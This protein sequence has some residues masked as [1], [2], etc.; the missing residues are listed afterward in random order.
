M[1]Q[2]G[3]VRQTAPKKYCARAQ[4]KSSSKCDVGLL[5][6]ENNDIMDDQSSVGYQ[7][8]YFTNVRRVCKEDAESRF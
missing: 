4:S 3:I 8:E 5:K 6:V 7:A 1:F 2:A